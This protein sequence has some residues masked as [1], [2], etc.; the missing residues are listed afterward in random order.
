MVP[1]RM[2]QCYCSVQTHR[3]GIIERYNERLKLS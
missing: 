3:T 2:Q 1:K